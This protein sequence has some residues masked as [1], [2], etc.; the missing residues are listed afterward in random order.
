MYVPQEQIMEYLVENLYRLRISV[1]ADCT[2]S[3]PCQ[4][5]D[6]SRRFSSA[7]LASPTAR[8]LPF[9]LIETQVTAFA[10]S[11]DVHV[12]DELVSTPQSLGEEG[13]EAPLET[14]FEII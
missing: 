3:K 6:P 5:L 7:K 14:D 2:R 11:R 8:N 4:Y 12:R 9:G 10:F 1:P 13:Y